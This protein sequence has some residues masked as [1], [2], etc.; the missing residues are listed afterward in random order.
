[1]DASCC[2]ATGST[3]LIGVDF[4]TDFVVSPL[5]GD[6]NWSGQLSGNQVLVGRNVRGFESGIGYIY[7]E[8]M[9]VIGVLASTG[10]DM[11]SSIIVNI[12][13]ARDLSM[14]VAG[15]GA[16][17]QSLGN[18]A[19]FVSCILVDADASSADRMANALAYLGD[20]SVIERSTVI[21]RSTQ[22]V[23]AFVAVLLVMAI[24]ACCMAALQLFA[25]YYGLVWD[26]RAELSLYSAVGASRMQLRALV[27]GEAVLLT[28]AG[29]ALGLVLG[30]TGY[31]LLV[32]N[33]AG[34]EGFPWI[35]PGVTLQVAWAL[36]ITGAFALISLAAIAAPIRRISH[37]D[38][39]L[40][41]QQRDLG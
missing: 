6:G 30:I 3:R 33:L 28:L 39:A 32:D 27:A 19:D 41:M 31:N 36:A 14:A 21:G 23:E 25:R 40:A 38:P 29:A 7:G 22:H 20:V 34:V 15:S 37:I 9:D 8:Q 12:D 17:W 24:L 26:R 4:S 1:V 35:A 16:F 10:T 5:V 18:P 2:S 11:D 13:K